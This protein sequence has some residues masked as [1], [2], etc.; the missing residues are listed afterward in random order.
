VINADE[1][2]LWVILLLALGAWLV[3]ALIIA[4]ELQWNRTHDLDARVTRHDMV[5]ERMQH[6]EADDE[7]QGE[8][9]DDGAHDPADDESERCS[10][11]GGSIL[12]TPVPMPPGIPSITERLDRWK[13]LS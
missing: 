2:P 12:P 5:A 1:L 9:A 7:I 4:G 13:D 11:H 3:Y 8:Q 6:S 10:I